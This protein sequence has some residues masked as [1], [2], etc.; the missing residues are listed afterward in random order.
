MIPQEPGTDHFILGEVRGSVSIRGTTPDLYA[1]PSAIFPADMSQFLSDT[2]IE[3]ILVTMSN[4]LVSVVYASSGAIVA[5]PDLVGYGESYEIPRSYFSGYNSAQGVVLAWLGAQEFVLDQSNG[6]TILEP[7]ATV[8]GYSE[9]GTATV[10]GALALGQIGVTVHS[11]YPGG[12]VYQPDLQ[13]AYIFDIFSPDTPPVPEGELISW[14]I[15]LPMIGYTTSINN[16]LIPN[17]GTDQIMLSE[18]YSMGD[19]QTNIYDWFNPPGQLTVGSAFIQF[20]PDNVTDVLNQ[21]LK[22]IY[23]ESRALGTA[24]ACLNFMSDTTDALCEAILAN[25]LIADLTDLVDFPT[26]ICNSP[27]DVSLLCVSFACVFVRWKAMAKLICLVS[28][29]CSKPCLVSCACSSL[30]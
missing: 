11:A 24:N 29:A 15:F 20:A 22:A 28:C 23:D 14:K 7:T 2:P 27:D 13:F 17:S 12:A 4:F 8:N 5:M 21:D 3:T 16:S 1:S 18:E 10:N 30:L 6:C 19:F 9:G 25:D 26:V